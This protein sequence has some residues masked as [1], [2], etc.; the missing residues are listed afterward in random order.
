[1]PQLQCHECGAPVGVDEPIPRDSECE[2]CRTD[3]RACINCRHYDTAY[4]NACR[5][6]EADPVPDKKRRNFCEFF[7]FSREPFARA[8]GG[9]TREAEAR[10]KLESL[11]GGAPA[12]SR[13]QTAREKLEGLFRDRK[14]EPGS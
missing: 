2:S 11:F 3:L 14:E 1:M 4:N 13:A 7:A 9:A 5:E 10:K 12:K 8:A 6:T